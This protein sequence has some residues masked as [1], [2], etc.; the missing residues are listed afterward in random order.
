[1][2]DSSY[3]GNILRET[4]TVI[5]KTQDGEWREHFIL[6][7]ICPKDGEILTVVF[8]VQSTWGIIVIFEEKRISLTTGS[9]RIFRN[10]SGQ[11]TSE[12]SGNAQTWIF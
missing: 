7:S 2:T 12:W 3:L 4:Q 10:I 8:D 6:P 5:I 1:M 9:K 11:W